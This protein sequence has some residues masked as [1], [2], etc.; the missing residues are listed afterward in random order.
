MKADILQYSYE[1]LLRYVVG[2]IKYYTPPC[3]MVQVPEGA[4]TS[5]AVPTLQNSRIMAY[6]PYL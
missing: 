2:K 3:D 6:L 5:V 1:L 4:V